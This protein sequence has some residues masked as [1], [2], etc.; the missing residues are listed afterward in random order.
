L[1]K[2]ALAT[3]TVAIR[4]DADVPMG[5]VSEIKQQLRTANALQVVY[6]TQKAITK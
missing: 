2:T 4:A 6:S 5:M 3:Y 1:P